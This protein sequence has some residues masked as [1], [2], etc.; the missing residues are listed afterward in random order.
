MYIYS[1]IYMHT[2]GFL[3]TVDA[4]RFEVLLWQTTVTGHY[5]QKKTAALSPSTAAL[6]A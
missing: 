5:I 3:Q 2:V 1:N 4:R 6:P